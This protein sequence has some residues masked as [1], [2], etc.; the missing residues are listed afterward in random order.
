MVVV[1]LRAGLLLAQLVVGA[2]TLVPGVPVERG[3][4][5]GESHA[6]AVAIRPNQPLLVTVDQRGIDVEIDVLG[7]D[8]RSLGVVDTP[9]GAEGPE[10]VLIDPEPEIQYRIEVR[11]PTKTAAPGRYEVRAE[12]LPL[13]TPAERERVK[14]ERLVTE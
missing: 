12:A 9:T 10:S 13:G 6:Y 1:S 11:S 4:A 3:L 5:G 8:G 7:P 2:S 14:A